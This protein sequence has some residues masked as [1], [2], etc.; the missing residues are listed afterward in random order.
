MSFPG[1]SGKTSHFLDHISGIKSSDATAS[2]KCAG[3][4][5]REWMTAPEYTL[6]SVCS[7]HG[8]ALRHGQNDYY[9]SSMTES[10]WLSQ[11]T[12]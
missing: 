1:F 7:S 2:G 10:E 12:P 4:N 11:S 3:H 8:D 5:E 9:D 6:E